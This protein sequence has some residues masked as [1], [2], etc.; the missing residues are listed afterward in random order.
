MPFK[1]N[2]LNTVLS[3]ETKRNSLQTSKFQEETLA[4]IDETYAKTTTLLGQNDCEVLGG[5]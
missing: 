4:S 5:L 2:S 3:A 1:K